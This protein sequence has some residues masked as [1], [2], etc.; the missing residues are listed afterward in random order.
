MLRRQ[1]RRSS[2]ERS[3]VAG[4]RR[5]G[6]GNSDLGR[7]EC[8]LTAMADDLS[9]DLDQ[10]LL[11][12]R[13]RPIFRL[14]RQG[15]GQGLVLRDASIHQVVGRN[16]A[17]R[18]DFGSTCLIWLCSD[19]SARPQVA[20]AIN[21]VVPRVRA[22][23]GHWPRREH[24][25]KRPLEKPSSPKLMSVSRSKLFLA[26]NAAKRLW[27]EKSAGSTPV[28]PGQAAFASIS[29]K[30]RISSLSSGSTTCSAA[31]VK[32][33][34]CVTR[35][36]ISCQILRWRLTRIGKTSTLHKSTAP[37]LRRFR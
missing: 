3:W 32:G 6:F 30:A 4:C 14:W 26:F 29:P 23:C 1:P 19:E 33:N 36:C 9:A 18:G 28:A 8:D 25:C 11:E 5:T 2:P 34:H 13:Q 21:V 20:A 7:L 12:G 24:A 17:R 10:L 22:I 16:Y 31:V 37:F 15:G 27:L 35:W